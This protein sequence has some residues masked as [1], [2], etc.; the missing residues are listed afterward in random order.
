[1]TPYISV[2][3]L[4]SLPRYIAG[5]L[6]ILQSYFGGIS[7]REEYLIVNG[8]MLADRGARSCKLT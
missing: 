7:I 6:G 3:L 2:T 4:S 1:M 5:R 8:G